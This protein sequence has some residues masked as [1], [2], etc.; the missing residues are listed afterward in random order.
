M[1]IRAAIY[2]RYSSDLQS[3][4]SIEDQ[5]RRCRRRLADEGWQEALVFTDH[6]RS[7]ASALRKGYQDLLQAARDGRIDMVVAEALDRLS[8]DLGDI[9]NFYKHLSFLGVRLVTL[10]EGEIGD[11]HVGLKGTMNALF[12]K[13]LAEKTRRGLEGRV[14]QG[15]S[16]GG[17]AYGYDVV[18]AYGSSGEA[19]RGLRVVNPDEARIVTRIFEEFAIGRSPTTIAKTLNAESIP[20]PRGG[21]WQDTAI[22]GHQTRGTGILNNEIYIGRL[23]WNRLRYVKDPSTGKRLSRANPPEE[24]VVANVP[25][26]QIIP[27][28]L[29]HRVKSRQPEISGNVGVRN[30]KAT[31]FW[32]ARRPRHL[33]TGKIA[34]GCCGKPLASIGRDYLGCNRARKQGT[35]NNGRSIRRDIVENEM[36][37]LLQDQLM[38]PIHVDEF[39]T[40]YNRELS[41]A[42]SESEQDREGKRRELTTVGRKLDGLYDA[43]ADGLRSPGLAAKLESLEAQKAELEEAIDDVQAT[44]PVLLHP[45]LAGLYQD[46]VAKLA[47]TLR[48]PSI[49]DEAGEILR[50]LV[51]QIIVTP[52]GMDRNGGWSIEL[53]GNIVEMVALANA[54]EPKTKR[55]ALD[56]RTARSVKVV[57]GARSRRY[58]HVDHAIL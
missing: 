19:D 9:A 47:E 21:A 39:I 33:L 45:N 11:L 50:D 15:R 24:W 5:V 18:T 14:R 35:C 25:D 23:V 8:R 13:D 43:T 56:E 44:A 17:N 36:M 10:A 28:D 31:R 41:V 27:D 6:A 37:A 49:R 48:A 42:A 58:L 4:A 51:D 52:C 38:Q 32:E 12:L 55:A 34:C 20:G 57:A 3:D 16:G 54:P 22:R 2:A 53:V 40:A 46:K 30:A 29:W 7:G 26:L 1:A